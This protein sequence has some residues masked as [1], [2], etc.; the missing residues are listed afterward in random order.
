M[1]DLTPLPASLP[2]AVEELAQ[3]VQGVRN[4]LNDSMVERLTATAG[5]SLEIVDKLDDPDVRAGLSALLDGIG[6]MHRNGAL[7]TVLETVQ[8]LH[9]VRRAASD[10]MVERAFSFIEHM[11]NNLGTEDLATLAHEAKAAM[12]DAIDHCA[13]PSAQGG[14]MGT[15]KMLSRPETQESLRFMLSFCCAL[16]KRVVAVAKTAPPQG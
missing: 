12:E 1:T 6:A 9:A 4:A 14:L 13:I 5:N 8:T 3:L 15:L 10:S 16:R 11:A 2:P 7:E